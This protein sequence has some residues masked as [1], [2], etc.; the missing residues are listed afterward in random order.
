MPSVTEAHFWQRIG[1]VFEA[2]RGTRLVSAVKQATGIDTKT[3][4]SIEAGRPGLVEKV[5]L[6]AKYLKLDLVDVIRSVLS[7]EKESFSPAVAEIRR[8]I[9]TLPDDAQQSLLMVTRSLS[10][11]QVGA[12]QAETGPTPAPPKGGRRTR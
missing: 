3:L 10:L 9:V 11:R 1:Q 6:Y 5:S 7:E 4:R 12:P 8:L 2:A